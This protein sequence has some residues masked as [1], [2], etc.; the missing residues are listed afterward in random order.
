MLYDK[1]HI[2]RMWMSSRERYCHSAV[3]RFLRN[4]KGFFFLES[5]HSLVI[6]VSVCVCVPNEFIRIVV[7]RPLTAIFYCLYF[8]MQFITKKNG[9]SWNQFSLIK[10]YNIFQFARNWCHQASVVLLPFSRYMALRHDELLTFTSD[11]SNQVTNVFRK[12]QPFF[13]CD[14]HFPPPNPNPCTVALLISQLFCDL[15]CQKCGK[16]QIHVSTLIFYDAKLFSKP[17]S[18]RFEYRIPT[19]FRI[20][21]AHAIKR[22]KFRQCRCY[23]GGIN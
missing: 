7:N 13:F 14:S 20:H 5:S 15:A 2:E 16:W 12:I 6:S 3:Y 21:G 10:N 1:F 19:C 8:T 22:E 9:D 11:T 4:I 18:M 17:L 23:S